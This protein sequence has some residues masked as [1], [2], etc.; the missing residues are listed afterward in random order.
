M[1]GP[2]EKFALEIGF[3]RLIAP[4]A[5]ALVTEPVLLP[6]DSFIACKKLLESF[7]APNLI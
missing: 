1:I 7:A 5:E 6:V 3:V 4:R 2:P